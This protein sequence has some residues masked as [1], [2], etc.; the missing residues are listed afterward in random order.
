[1]WEA[2]ERVAKD[3]FE[4]GWLGEDSGWLI[5]RTGVWSKDVEEE[6]SG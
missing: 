1:L 4:E 3:V 2:L 6:L 5:G